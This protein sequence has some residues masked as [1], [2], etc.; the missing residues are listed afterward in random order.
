MITAKEGLDPATYASVKLGSDSGDIDT[1]L[2]AI[3]IV[4]D[5]ADTKNLSIVNEM[6]NETGDDR[7][8]IQPNDKVVLI[9]EDD[10]R[11]AKIMIDKAQDRKT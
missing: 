8:N 5:R 3:G 4:N 9:V 2:N 7:T 1:L 11:F 6:I 10:L